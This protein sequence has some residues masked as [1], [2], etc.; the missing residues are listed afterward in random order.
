[1]RRV[2]I[3]GGA[4]FAGSTLALH[5]KRSH[6]DDE[7]IAF[8]NLRR[9]GSE[10]ALP[11]LREGGVRFCHGDLRNP[12]DLAT[13]AAA[14]L[15]IDCAAEPSVQAGQGDE[16]DALVRNNLFSTLNCLEF[17]RRHGA[18]LVFL[19]TSRVYPIAGL[20]GLPL[21]TRGARLELPR[22]AEGPG[23]STRGIRSDFPMPGSRSLYGATKLASEL[24]VQE[25]HALHGL[26]AVIYRCGVLAGP[27]QMGRVDQGFVA[28]WA[29][30][31]LWGEHLDYRGFGGEG[32][33]VRDV[34][35]IDDL[36]D[37]IER[38]VPDLENLGAKIFGVGGGHENSVSLL[39]LSELCAERCGQ[40]L[41]IGR[42]E[43]THPTDVPYFVTDNQEVSQASGWE[44]GRGLEQ[45]LDDVMSWLRDAGPELKQVLGASGQTPSGAGTP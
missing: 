41:E 28:L 5:W 19:S 8:D 45:V 1:M 15:V 38:Q 13:L 22:G 44:P 24:L 26:P 43:E 34:L 18:G 14:Q 9:A 39:E 37:L 11:R 35:H 36:F 7:V 30:R 17:C 33:Q 23:W 6:V 20:R 4:G 32:R 16:S 12:E 31:H 21:E 3:T 10:L 29:A 25:Y 40:S 42:V 27:W 2:L